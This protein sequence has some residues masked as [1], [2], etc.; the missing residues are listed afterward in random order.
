MS[1]I[2]P[3]KLTTKSFS[4]CY[5]DG[6]TGEPI[7]TLAYLNNTGKVKDT[8]Q[9][10]IDNKP[11]F[12]GLVMWDINEVKEEE[13]VAGKKRIVKGFWNTGNLATPQTNETA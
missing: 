6:N 2:T 8:M 5:Y 1:G 7:S 10:A 13:P 12:H 3:P 4:I 11:E 9:E